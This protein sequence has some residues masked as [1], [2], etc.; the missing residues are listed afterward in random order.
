MTD[1]KL[2]EL[3][4]QELNLFQSRIVIHDSKENNDNPELSRELVCLSV[5]VLS[6]A[7]RYDRQQ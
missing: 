2:E 6:D 1:W 4:E 5:I 7:Y 3:R